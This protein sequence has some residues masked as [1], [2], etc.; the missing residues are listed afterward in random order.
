[1]QDNSHRCHQVCIFSITEQLSIVILFILD[2]FRA[3]YIT[4][5]VQKS[6]G[7]RELLHRHVANKDNYFLLRCLLATENVNIAKIIHL[8]SSSHIWSLFAQIHKL[9]KSKGRSIASPF[10]HFSNHKSSIHEE[11][12]G[13]HFTH[14]I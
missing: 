2:V 4:H 9:T 6:R 12:S 11:I 5:H 3:R 7:R 14:F 1:M 8:G 13:H 10:K